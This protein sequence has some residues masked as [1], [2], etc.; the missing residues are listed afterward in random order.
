VALGYLSHC[1]APIYASLA[2][3]PY[4]GMEAYIIASCGATGLPGR[5]VDRDVARQ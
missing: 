3:S 5:I 2:D 1:Y 4:N